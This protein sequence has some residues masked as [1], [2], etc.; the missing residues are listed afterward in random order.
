MSNSLWLTHK[1]VSTTCTCVADRRRAKVG[2]LTLALHQ[3]IAEL[4]AG[5]LSDADEGD[6]EAEFAALAELAAETAPELPDAPTHTVVTAAA[7]PCKRRVIFK[8]TKHG[9]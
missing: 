6:V 2:V 3:D 5:K 4:L 1:T 7:V 9:H 8:K